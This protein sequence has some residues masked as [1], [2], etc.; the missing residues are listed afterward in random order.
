MPIINTGPR[1]SIELQARSQE[2]FGRALG[3]AIQASE[4]RIDR[5]TMREI[6][7]RLVAEMRHPV[8]GGPTTPGPLPSLEM[9]AAIDPYTG[10]IA[11]NSPLRYAGT[12]TTSTSSSSRSNT[13]TEM[14]LVQQ[15]AN[16]AMRERLEAPPI[17]SAEALARAAALVDV[18]DRPDNVW[19]RDAAAIPPTIWERV[20]TRTYSKPDD[21]EDMARAL[22]VVE[23]QTL[24]ALRKLKQLGWVWDGKDWVYDMNGLAASAQA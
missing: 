23:D 13:A 9:L 5:E 22:G 4:E 17:L 10:L 15:Q 1:P 7:E 19:F 18:T 12:V 2:N 24:G 21:P 3:P 6:R 16:R 14:L 20:P 8:E 11:R